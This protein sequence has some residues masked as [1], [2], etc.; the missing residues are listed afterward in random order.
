MEK[1]ISLAISLILVTWYYINS[2]KLNFLFK[3]T[4]NWK[5]SI[6][7][8][9]VFTYIFFSVL[10]LFIDS[11]TISPDKELLKFKEDFCL[12]FLLIFEIFIM[13]LAPLAYII[14]YETSSN[15]NDNKNTID[16]NNQN[17]NSIYNLNVAIDDYNFIKNNNYS[18]CQQFDKVILEKGPEKNSQKFYLLI[19]AY[20][21]YMILLI[22]LNVIFLKIKFED[23]F[24]NKMD[25]IN[26]YFV[27]DQTN[28]DKE[29][30]IY[31]TK[32]PHGLSKYA[33]IKND[34]QKIIYFNFGLLMM[35]GKFLGFTYMP[36][37]MSL[38]V[39]DMI[40]Q[41]DEKFT[42]KRSNNEELNNLQIKDNIERIILYKEI[43]DNNSMKM[44]L[45]PIDK[46]ANSNNSDFVKN[47]SNGKNID[48]NQQNE[49]DKL[50]PVVNE[51]SYKDEDL[52]KH[53]KY[54]MKF[55]SNTNL[56]NYKEENS[57]E[58]EE[59]KEKDNS[60]EK[61]IVIKTLKSYS[62]EKSNKSNFYTNSNSNK[63]N[64]SSLFEDSKDSASIDRSD[65]FEE[66]D[67]LI[68]KD[69]K[70]KE[71]HKIKNNFKTKSTESGGLISCEAKSKNSSLEMNNGNICENQNTI[72]YGKSNSNIDYEKN[73]KN[74]YK[75]LIR[76]IQTQETIM[77]INNENQNKKLTLENKIS[78]LVVKERK[79]SNERKKSG[80][81]IL[82]LKK[83]KD[84]LVNFET[85]T[86]NSNQRFY[87]YKN[88]LKVFLYT[89]LIII[90]IITIYLIIY[91][92]IIILYSKIVYNICGSECGFLSYR[93][94]EKFTFDYISYYL[95]NFSKNKYLKFDFFFFASILIFRM[96]TVSKAIS[97]KGVAFLWNIFYTPN[98]TL[99]N[100][101]VF[102]LFSVIIYT[103]MVLLYDFTYLFPDYLRFN[104]L[105][106]FC[107]YTTI[108]KDY[109]GVSFFGLLFLKI[110]MN[111]Q[112]FMYFD[113][114][115][116][117][118][119]ISNGIIWV[120]R[121]IV[122]PLAYSMFIKLTER[123]SG[124]QE[125]IEKDL[126]I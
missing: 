67:S 20:C 19:F 17:N 80:N 97:V 76:N 111:F 31:G 2:L 9:F 64:N 27:Y 43:C 108:D 116:S 22:S 47:N 126:V 26:K 42:N 114:L 77:E 34:Y 115:A 46:K 90:C 102:V 12:N 58:F 74:D 35:L 83:S 15:E 50:I 119:F 98:H 100:Y 24:N 33:Y 57:N 124:K 94:G 1:F 78:D 18:E 117:G 123:H 36:Y 75:N 113:I 62:D 14:L 66:D 99:K 3:N 125:R 41:K 79:F 70:K 87:T 65:N 29:Y 54:M 37:G 88:Y 44:A 13:I 8:I 39:H 6:L 72:S 104:G 5:Y 52:A 11:M 93:F 81:Q 122:K 63:T 25:K 23:F 110:S 68:L 89:L 7:S 106:N 60:N 69:V 10:F 30:E 38:L 21:C 82:T 91:S 40:F 61:K 109:C 95:I 45:N 49:Y 28:S 120:F 59:S 86:E 112:V 53:K 101:Q 71:I 32:V 51:N 85:L 48:I 103:A 84:V 92:K 4:Q 56:K 107:D 121:L 96:L 105:K 55:L 118:I 73:L 16:S